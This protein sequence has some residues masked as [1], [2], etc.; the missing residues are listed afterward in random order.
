MAKRISVVVSQSP[1][2]NPAKRKLEEDIDAGL[3][4]ENGIDVTIVP[5][6][7]DIKPESTGMLALR[8]IAGNVV[9]VS[10]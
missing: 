1:S 4:L 6:L 5:N 2:K 7:Y 3:L 8:Q 9:V 10:W